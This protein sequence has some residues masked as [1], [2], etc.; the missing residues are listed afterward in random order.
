[1]WREGA[2]EMRFRGEAL[3]D[4]ELRMGMRRSTNEK[5]RRYGIPY[6]ER[7]QTLSRIDSYERKKKEVFKVDSG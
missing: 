1:M 5:A 7:S 6:S 4:V 3:R 2:G